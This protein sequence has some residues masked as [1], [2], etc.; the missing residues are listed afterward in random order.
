MAEI[1]KETIDYIFN[2]YAGLFN[3]EEKAALKHLFSLVKLD[4]D[5]TDETMDSRVKAYRERGWLSSRKE[6]LNMIKDGEEA[7]R[8]RVANRVLHEQ[9]DQIYFN[10]CKSCGRLARTP[11]ARQCRYC[12][13]N[14]H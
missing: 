12:G 14:W 8:Q 4:V 5:D 13:L 7:F 2:H 1:D 3:L 6:I 10:Y 11:L 9:S